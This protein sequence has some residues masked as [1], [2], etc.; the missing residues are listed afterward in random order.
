MPNDITQNNMPPGIGSD[1]GYTY[2]SGTNED[3]IVIDEV[4][5]SSESSWYDRNKG[6]INP[7][8]GIGA[9][10]ATGGVAWL[11]ALIGGLF[12]IGTTILQNHYNEKNYERQLKDAKEAEQRANEEY[13][14]RQADARTYNDAWDQ[15]LL[16][17][18]YNPLA[19]LNKGQ[20]ATSTSASSPS[21]AT[22]PGRIPQQTSLANISQ[23]MAIAQ[24][25]A[26]IQQ[27]KA[28][29]DN[30]R[31]DTQ[32]K[33]QLVSTF[34]ERFSL[35]MQNLTS[36]IKSRDSQT[37]L[38]TLSAQFKEATMSFDFAKA[39]YATQQAY[40]E[41]ERSGISVDQAKA[42][43]TFRL[44][45]I[46]QQ[47]IQS[48]LMEQQLDLNEVTLDQL[49]T[50]WNANK[51]LVD[52]QA[53]AQLSLLNERVRSATKANNWYAVNQV[54]GGLSS[55]GSTV[56]SLVN[57]FKPFPQI[58]ST[59]TERSTIGEFGNVLGTTTEFRQNTYSK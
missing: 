17:K 13:D 29:T 28:T 34:W 23:A 58:T 49:V 42:D 1:A 22:L 38:N 41:M 54:I 14:R 5:I 9:G 56:S 12:G 44:N 55:I 37:R 30:I 31:S 36:T 46:A 21:M 53:Q 59:Y 52:E 10:V 7:L 8:L 47:A 19:L 18:G 15:R 4:P 43:L 16:E 6:W 33:D 26:Q 45:S 48:Q 57:A 35:E 3:P 50:T 27:T 11:P 24:Q 20:G 51:H 2:G 40:Y 25:V 32:Q 39:Q